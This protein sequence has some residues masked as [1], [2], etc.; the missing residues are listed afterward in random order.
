MVQIFVNNCPKKCKAVH[1]SSLETFSSKQFF[2]RESPCRDHTNTL[3][4]SCSKTFS[5]ASRDFRIILLAF[6]L[7]SQ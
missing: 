1:C 6:E 4:P 5:V 3:F 7:P 2:T